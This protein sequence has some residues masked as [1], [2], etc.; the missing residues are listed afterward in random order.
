MPAKNPRINLVLEAPLYESVKRL[1]AS[2][3]V[4]LSLKARELIKKALEAY[5]DETLARVAERR[6]GNLEPKKA[7]HHSEVW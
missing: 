5:E 6:A 7:L 4:S 3:G 2:E 1:A